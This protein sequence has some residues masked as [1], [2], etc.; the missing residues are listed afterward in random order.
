[1]FGKTSK[2]QP[3]APV[4]RAKRGGSFSVIGADATITGNVATSDNLQVNGRIDGDVRCGVLHQGA[5]GIIAGH[6]VAEEVRLAGLVDGTVNA[7]LVVL[8]PSARVTGDITYETLSIEGGA[9]VEG[10]FAHRGVIEA[11]A[12]MGSGAGRLTEL[13]PPEET[14][15]AAE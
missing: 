14:A 12:S 11:H 6:I 10:R 15:Q 7:S 3:A 8:E 9:R 1:M 5:G 13:F 4:R 2:D